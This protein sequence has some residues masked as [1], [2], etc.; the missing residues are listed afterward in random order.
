MFKENENPGYLVG[1]FFTVDPDKDL[2]NLNIQEKI[3]TRK[4]KNKKK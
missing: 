3:N 1:N 2:S 4:N